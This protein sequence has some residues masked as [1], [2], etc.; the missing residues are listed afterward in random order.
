MTPRQCLNLQWLTRIAVHHVNPH[1]QFCVLLWSSIMFDVHGVTW[2]NAAEWLEC[3]GPGRQVACVGE[4]GQLCRLGFA[5]V[6]H[7]SLVA[8]LGENR[9]PKCYIARAV[10]S[11]CGWRIAKLSDGILWAPSAAAAAAGGC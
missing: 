10:G 1:C 5:P 7:F 4:H 9:E 11:R 8:E 2:M 3:E 6:L